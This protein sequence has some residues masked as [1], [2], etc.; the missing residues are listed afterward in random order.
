MPVAAAS[1]GQV[2]HAILPSGEPVAVKV[3]YP[4]VA[5]S[6]N[7]DLATLRS[8][9][10]LGGLLPKGLYLDNTIRVARV[11]LAWECDYKRESENSE[12][13]RELLKL[14]EGFKV[15]K[16]IKELST[17]QVLTT[18]FVEGLPIGE[19]GSLPQAVR[20]SVCSKRIYNEW[21]LHKVDALFHLR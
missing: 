6:I 20:D 8:L 12:R 3:Q 9:V 5:K 14:H 10:L 17:K 16:V 19:T 7:S 4:G 1:V 21:L 11:E 13:M 18:E 15:P 2:H